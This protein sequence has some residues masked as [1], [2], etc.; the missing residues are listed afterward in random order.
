MPDK[1]ADNPVGDEFAKL[2]DDGTRYTTTTN[3]G[4]HLAGATISTKDL[5]PGAQIQR[6][7]EAGALVPAEKV[8]PNK[9]AA[10]AG[11]AAGRTDPGLN[12]GKGPPAP[13]HDPH[14]GSHPE[15]GL[16]GKPKK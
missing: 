12:I 5:G 2:T 16:E 13:G 9:P 15:S 11:P 6:L 14:P 1:I 3:V 7:I 8:D 10:A 4:P